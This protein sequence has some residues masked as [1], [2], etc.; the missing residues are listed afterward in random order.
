[1]NTYRSAV[2]IILLCLTLALAGCTGTQSPVA[3]SPTN[4]PAASQSSPAAAGPD[5]NPSPTDS[6][7]DA[8]KVNINVE[9]DY[10]AN[11]II[12]FQGGNGLAQV[13]RID[14][15]LNRA[16]GQVNTATIGT[17][18]GDSVTFEGTKSTD[19]V[20]VYVT[21]KD[22]KQY[23]LVDMNVPYRSRQ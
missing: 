19:R 5:L 11:V 8:N 21:M 16:D 3:A 10:L 14:A 17:R 22:G 12:T 20:I 4:A 13:N 1:M 18:V 23:K 15:T 2:I 6:I 7:I 9:K